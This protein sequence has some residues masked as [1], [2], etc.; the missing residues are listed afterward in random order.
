MLIKKDEEYVYGAL[1][2]VF[3]NKILAT[4]AGAMEGKYDWLKKGSS[5]AAYFFLIKWGKENGFSMIDLGKCRSFINDGLFKYKLK[6]NTI[7][8]RS[9]SPYDSIFALKILKN[10]EATRS[11][12]LS[13]PFIYQYKQNLNAIFFSD[14]KQNEI[15]QFI[16]LNNIQG[17]E[18]IEIIKPSKFIGQK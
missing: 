4:Y 13:N 14:I 8:T 17:L 3:D 12:L 2:Q 10:N 5:A 7:I 18:K 1:F 6:W 9:S 16:K 15:K 11:F